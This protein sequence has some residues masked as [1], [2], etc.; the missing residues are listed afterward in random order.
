MFYTL[1]WLGNGWESR[2]VTFNRSYN[3]RHQDKGEDAMQDLSDHTIKRYHLRERLGAGGF[4]IVYKAYQPVVER[5]V[6][7]KII[8]SGLANQPDFIEY[9]A[10][11]S[12]L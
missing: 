11:C 8:L 3:K 12:R 4:G 9:L 6:A 10:D 5:D 7:I 2:D 1:F